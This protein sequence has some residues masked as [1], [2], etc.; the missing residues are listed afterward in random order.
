M[1]WNSPSQVRPRGLRLRLHFVI[2]CTSSLCRLKKVSS[3][4][5]PGGHDPCATS[6]KNPGEFKS[7]ATN[8]D[9]RRDSSLTGVLSAVQGDVRFRHNSDTRQNPLHCNVTR[10]E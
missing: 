6:V 7:A 2:A 5:S 8:K 4:S 9:Q 10:V 1:R 3:A